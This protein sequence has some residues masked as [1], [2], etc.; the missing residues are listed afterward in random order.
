MTNNSSYSSAILYWEQ[1]WTKIFGENAC[2]KK[3]LKKVIPPPSPPKKKK[4]L[5]SRNA[6]DE[7]NLLGSCKL[8]SLIN[9]LEVFSFLSFFCFF[10]IL[11][12]CWFFEIKN[13]FSDTHLTMWAG[14]WE[15]NF[16]S[17]DFQK[18]DYFFWPVL[19]ICC[20]KAALDV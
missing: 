13:I 7:E 19:S 4:K 2:N 18:Q 11:V 10:F 3:K 16:H 6:C 14:E 15:K 5:I 8:F 12:V 20:H 9:F 17:A 1:Y